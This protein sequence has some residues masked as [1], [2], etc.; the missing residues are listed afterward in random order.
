MASPSPFPVVLVH[1]IGSSA[2]ELSEV[3]D[4]LSKKNLSVYNMNV[5]NGY[6]DSI[7]IPMLDQLSLLTE[8]I[9]SIEEL[10]NGFNIIGMSQGGLL[11][12]GYV[13]ISMGNRNDYQVNNLI[14]WVS[15]HGGIFST[16]YKM[17]NVY[18]LDTQLSYSYSNYWRNPLGYKY[19]EYLDS[20]LYLAFLNN[21]I[22]TI[23][24]RE[25]CKNINKVSHFVMIWSP[26]D[27][28]LSPP[29]SGKFST[30]DENLNVIAL[31]ETST[32]DS[33]CLSSVNIE[34]F[35]TNCTHKN[36]RNN[37]CF[38]YLEKYTLPFII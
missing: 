15:P 32:F 31:N 21:E 36:H 1:G 6:L 37:E 33:L 12:R 5:G 9:L 27:E 7:F 29:E 16:K 14:T 13:Q 18:D 30:Y 2:D 17:K 22:E 11:A 28:V 3:Q 8:E 35:E 19:D 4:Y 38:D 24:S 23:F 25:N 10:K 20:S 34:I 26:N